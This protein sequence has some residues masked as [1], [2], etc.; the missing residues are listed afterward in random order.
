LDRNFIRFARLNQP[1]LV[2][3]E[4]RA[5]IG[6]LALQRNRHCGNKKHCKPDKGKAKS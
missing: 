5:L 2:A 3:G 1:T 6:A 4:R